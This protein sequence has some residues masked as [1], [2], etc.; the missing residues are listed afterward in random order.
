MLILKRHGDGQ[1]CERDFDDTPLA[2]ASA[3]AD[4]A[5]FTSC[6]R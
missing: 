4:I 2:F 3:D 5:N 6:L 1:R